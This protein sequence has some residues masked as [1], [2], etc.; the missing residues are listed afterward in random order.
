MKN[1]FVLA[2]GKSSRL[3]FD[4]LNITICGKGIVEIIDQNMGDLFDNKFVVVKSK[5]DFKMNNFKVVK[6]VLDIEA[7]VAGVITSLMHSQCD[8]NFICACDMPFINR[9]LVEY[10]LQFEGFDAVVPFYNGYFEPLCSVYS[11]TFLNIALECV[12]RG[13]LSLSFALKNSNVKKIELEEILRFDK[14]L[15]SFKNINTAK[16]LEE[17]NEKFKFKFAKYI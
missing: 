4:K 3:G 14:D 16:D 6:D 15:V 5:K 9:D 7:P 10:M 17:A 11:R 1:L 13:I 2:G 8:K 12:A